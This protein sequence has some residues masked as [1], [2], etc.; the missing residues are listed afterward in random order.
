MSQSRR[1]LVADAIPLID[2]I[3]AELKL[4]LAE[5]RNP[6]IIRASAAKARAVINKYYA[7]TD[8]SKM[9]RM[10]MSK[11]NVSCSLTSLMFF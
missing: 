3:D 9:Y 6:K 10:C 2:I 1:P 8:D 4:I 11:L 7:K 5:S